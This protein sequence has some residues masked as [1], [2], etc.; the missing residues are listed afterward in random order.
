M[1]QLMRERSRV[2]HLLFLFVLA[3]GLS[4]ARAQTFSFQNDRLPAAE[5]KG[6]F[7]FHT[8]DDPR[9][10]APGFD[11]SGWQLLRS[12]EPWSSQGY[13]GYGGVAWYRF[14]VTVPAEDPA[15]ALWAPHILAPYLNGQEVALENGLPLGL[16]A[17]SGYPETTR[18]LA[19]GARLTMLTDGVVEARSPTGELFGFDRTAAISTQSAE[20]ISHAAQ[21]FGQEDD[22]R[23]SLRFAPA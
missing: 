14:A 16:A 10:A 12:D 2:V 17:E 20:A 7:R 19:P 22:T 3:C 18:R 5:L 6:R 13:R 8:G 23:S 1:G 21:R 4:P 11:D 9:W 15:L